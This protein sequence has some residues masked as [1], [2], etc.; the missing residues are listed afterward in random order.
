VERVRF[1]RKFGSFLLFNNTA[2]GA[3]VGL[4]VKPSYSFLIP[5]A[6]ASNAAALPAS[7]SKRYTAAQ[8][9]VQT[10]VAFLQ[11]EIGN[12]QLK[13][14][15]FPEIQLDG[16]IVRLV[17]FLGTARCCSEGTKSDKWCKKQAEE[18]QKTPAGI[19]RAISRRSS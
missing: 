8:R 18:R 1:Q 11:V 16:R 4:M 2:C 19:L 17:I 3:G 13:S 14:S 6:F 9:V 10:D 12:P 7:P 5:A 15:R